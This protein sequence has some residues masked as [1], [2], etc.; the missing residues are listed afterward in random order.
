MD[1]TIRFQLT[2]VHNI[3][4]TES[5]KPSE[6]IYHLKEQGNGVYFIVI[7]G[8][9]EINENALQ[10]RDALGVWNISDA[11]SINFLGNTKLLA[12]EIPMN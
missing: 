8:E 7:E 5:N 1:K 9:A 2:K 4:I 11:V 3:S 10:K 6:N 12:I